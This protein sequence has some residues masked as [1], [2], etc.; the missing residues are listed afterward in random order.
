MT[1]K[2]TAIKQK[3]KRN[4]ARNKRK[5]QMLGFEPTD[6]SLDGQLIN[7]WATITGNK[8]KLPEYYHTYAH[9]LWKY[10]SAVTAVFEKIALGA[11]RNCRCV[12]AYIVRTPHSCYMHRHYRNS[13][14]RFFYVHLKP[15][16]RV[17]YKEKD[18]TCCVCKYMYLQL[19]QVN[20]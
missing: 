16:A 13:W 19:K 11:I 8:F 7:H 15:D 9:V 1:E 14:K 18:V 5:V 3:I 6:A 17:L 2:N 12:T 10:A 4:I 20:F